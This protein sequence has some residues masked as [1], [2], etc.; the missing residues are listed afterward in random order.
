MIFKEEGKLKKP[1]ILVY[2]FEV[3]KEFIYLG[4]KLKC[5]GD[6]SR[7]KESKK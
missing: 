1:R 6:L 3:L 4:L 2:A 7:K 5:S